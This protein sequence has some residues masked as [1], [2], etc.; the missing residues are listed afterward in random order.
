MRK[1]SG[2]QRNIG[3]LA[4]GTKHG[5]IVNAVLDSYEEGVENRRNTD[6][7]RTLFFLLLALGIVFNLLRAASALLS[8]TR[9]LDSWFGVAAEGGGEERAAPPQSREPRDV[10]GVG[11]L[12]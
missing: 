2:V 9:C 1:I 7:E 10:D 3:S 5:H 4:N 11:Q 6:D 8:S 12:S